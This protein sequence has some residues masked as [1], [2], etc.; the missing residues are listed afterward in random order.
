MVAGPKTC[1]MLGQ[2]A[3]GPRPPSGAGSVRSHCWVKS[4]PALTMLYQAFL[5]SSLSRRAQTI[6][7]ASCQMKSLCFDDYSCCTTSINIFLEEKQYN[8]L[9]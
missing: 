3:M 7:N 5:S 6:E 9:P 1:R 2:S 4:L 8:M